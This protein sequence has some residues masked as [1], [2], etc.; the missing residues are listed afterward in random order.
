VLRFPARTQSPKTLCIIKPMEKR[1]EEDIPILGRV[2][3]NFVDL[4]SRFYDVYLKED[5]VERQRKTAH[6]GLISKAFKGINHSR[7]DYL[8]LQCVISEL[9]DNNFKGTTSA[10]GS[11]KINGKNY[12]GNDIIK[13]WCLFSN[14]G[15]C[16]NTIGDEKTLL[17]KAI[18]H[19]RFRTFL[20][21]SIQDADLKAWA[22]EV[23]D[24]F[25]YVS[26]HH[27][28]SLRR[29]YKCLP[30]RLA[31]KKE[32]IS[33]YK[34][35]LLDTESTSHIANSMQVEQLKLIYR[36]IRDLSIISLDTRNSSLPVSIDILS[37]VLSF[38][39]YENR[40]QETKSNEIFNP[41]LS[42]LCDELYLHTKSQTYQRSYEVS[43]MSSLPNNF[44]DIIDKALK[45]GLSDA[46]TNDL[47][48][49]LR[50]E[51]HEDYLEKLDLKGALRNVLTVKREITDVEASLDFNPFSK[52]RV[53]DFYIKKD[54]FTPKMLPKFLSNI[55]GILEKQISGTVKNHVYNRAALIKGIKDGMKKV[56]LDEEASDT[57]LN[58]LTDQIYKESWAFVQSQ[59]IPTFRD[60]LWAV[61]RFH[62]RDQ[63]YFEI[64]HHISKTYNFFGVRFENG[65][66]LLNNNID[67][68]ITE[69]SD[70]DR[71]HEL[72]QL[73]RSTKKA[74]KGTTIACIARITIYDYSKSPDKRKVTDIDSLVLKF[75][76]EHVFL[77]L[78][79]S[80]NT[81]RPF[82]DAKKDLKDKLIKVLNSNTNG[83]Q[84]REVKNYGAKIAI[85]HDTK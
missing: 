65:I 15:H 73:Q 53:M 6:L 57:I 77:E 49:F 28:L 18:Q 74:F 30:R 55:N 81:K 45:E 63:Y 29:I 51:L 21:G 42:L 24:E 34:L 66:D 82:I 79:E 37:T 70:P 71:I 61:L 4:A 27:I 75:N 50:T 68:A 32:L 76:Q 40:H 3:V 72:K 62:I 60:I 67:T 14:F 80:K 35:L 5:E 13:S 7:F 31:F 2:Y 56:S 22:G 1:I 64:D 33:V 16:K 26:F 54:G 83:Y 25:D 47:K 41:L 23:I 43:A 11:I 78:H 59:N 58:S 85:K 36:N 52:V 8:I 38:D 17:L 20:I 44:S 9:A 12:F 39:F 84:I 48:H 19:K 69:N 10:Q 46:E